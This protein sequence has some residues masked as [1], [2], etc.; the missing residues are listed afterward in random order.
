M[1]LQ[2][3]PEEQGTVFHAWWE[4]VEP[5]QKRLLAVLGAI[6]I[7]AAATAYLLHARTAQHV[8]TREEIIGYAL[9]LF[10]GLVLMAPGLVLALLDRM[11]LPT[12]LHRRD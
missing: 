7:A 9:F 11:P 10:V 3:P 12:W 6:T 2:V 1:K 4:R 8:H 5:W